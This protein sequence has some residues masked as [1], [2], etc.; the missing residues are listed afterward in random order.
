MLVKHSSVRFRFERAL[1]MM[2][3]LIETQFQPPSLGLWQTLTFDLALLGCCGTM[4]VGGGGGNTA[5]STVQIS[6]RS[7]AVIKVGGEI[8]CCWHAVIWDSLT[9]RRHHPPDTDLR[10]PQAFTHRPGTVCCQ[11][12]W[13]PAAVSAGSSG[14]D[15]RA[16]ST[17]F[18]WR[19]AAASSS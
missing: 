6:I 16:W 10:W 11:N 15:Q 17:S 14:C 8:S 19:L 7:L 18:A 4:W 5:G 9:Q 2:L 3:T 12:K 13:R 1:Q